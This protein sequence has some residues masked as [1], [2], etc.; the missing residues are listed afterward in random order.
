M[1]GLNIVATFV[2]SVIKISKFGTIHVVSNL[3]EHLHK[4]T[5]H[6]NLNKNFILPDSY[7]GNGQSST[8]KYYS[9]TVYAVRSTSMMSLNCIREV[10]EYRESIARKTEC[11]LH[12]ILLK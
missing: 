9:S 12:S 10:L 11:R 5:L 1:F 4:H 8:L 2:S 3:L 6:L 7:F